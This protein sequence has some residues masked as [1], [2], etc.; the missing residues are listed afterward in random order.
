MRDS[1]AKIP[2]G[3]TEERMRMQAKSSEV[4]TSELLNL[5]NLNIREIFEDSIKI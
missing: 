3:T 4:T 5:C 1:V 2:I